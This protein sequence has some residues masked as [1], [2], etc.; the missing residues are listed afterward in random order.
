MVS[1]AFTLLVV[2]AI[3]ALYFLPSIVAWH[4]EHSNLLALFVLNL[5]A[6]WTMIGW[7]GAIV[8]ALYVPP[9]QRD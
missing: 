7:V 1:L 6:G 5:L 4:R 9:G 8:W 2:S 3:C